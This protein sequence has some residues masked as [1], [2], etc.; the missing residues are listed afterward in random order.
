MNRREKTSAAAAS[1]DEPICNRSNNPT[2]NGIL[3]AHLD[4][5]DVL[6]GGLAA[7]VTGYFG[8]SFFGLASPLAQEKTPENLL[9]FAP[10]KTSS[11]DTVTVPPG[12]RTQVILRWGEPLDGS[13]PA[14]SIDASGVDQERQVGSHHDGMHFFPIEGQSPFEGSSADG[15]LVVNHEYVEPRFLHAAAVGTEADSDGFPLLAGARDADQV[16]KEL[17]AHGV[18]I[19]RIRKGEDG[20]WAL[21]RDPRNRR[22]TG[23]TPIAI[24]GPVRGSSLVKTKYSPDGTMTRGT[25]NNCAH[26]VTP[27]NTYLAAEENW[28]GYFRNGDLLDQKPNLP[29][30]HGR[31][32]VK[33]ER[34]RYGWELADNG[35]DEFL[36][37]DASA[38]GAGPEDDY[39]NEPNTFGW[40]VE[41]DPFDPASTP[42][43]RTAL[44]RFAHEGVVFAPPREGKPVVC[45]SGD[46][47]RF[48]YIYKFVSAKAYRAAVSGGDLLDEGTLFVAKFNEDGS[49][50]WLPLIHGRN[51]LTAA[52]GFVDQADILVSTRTAADT[53]GATKMDRPEWG[54]VDPKTGM[55]YFT[56]TNNSRRTPDQVDAANPRAENTFGHIIRWREAGDDP[57]A[58]AFAWDLFVLAGDQTQGR[59]LGGRPLT[60]DNIFSSPD[61]LW[62][63]HDGRLWIQ[64]D[65]SESALNQGAHTVFG[66]NQMLAADPVSGEIRRFLTGPVGQEIT[67]VVTTPD[68]KTMFVNVQHPGATTSAGDFAAGVLNSHWPDGGDSYPRSAT[69]A[70][71]KEDGGVIGT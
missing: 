65:I 45:Y 6:V 58:T 47:A 55:V 36:R 19:A 14:F 8:S 46:D 68:G 43:K 27:W 18:T 63:D 66:N 12:Y 4:R 33:T 57:A 30:E 17:N 15:F 34:S 41:I 32:G 28:A 49:G 56:L 62:F 24:S 60:E 38:K 16:L 69:V 50:E 39:R 20:N 70:I 1:G 3:E 52:N 26:G 64:T 59:D 13:F 9:G 71:T 54:A 61:G 7:A 37:F 21:E 51:G 35:A 67:G 5:R 23:L 29:R 53:V 2:F 22:I 10:I 25:L 48:E 44:G 11:A 40:I 42:V 31:Y